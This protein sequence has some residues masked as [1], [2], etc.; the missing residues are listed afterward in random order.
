M[1]VT[2]ADSPEAEHGQLRSTKLISLNLNTLKRATNSG[3]TVEIYL[4]ISPIW[5]PVFECL[6]QKQKII[7]VT[8]I[9]SVPD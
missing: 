8:N 4:L 5:G 2:C 7:I 1:P 6:F 3:M 9:F